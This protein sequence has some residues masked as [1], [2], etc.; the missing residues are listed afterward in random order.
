MLEL[1]GYD[2]SRRTFNQSP[3]ELSD[4]NSA[5]PEDGIPWRRVLHC[6]SQLA[7]DSAP[8]CWCYGEAYTSNFSYEGFASVD[9]DIQPEDMKAKIMM[10]NCL[11]FP[12]FTPKQQAHRITVS[13]AQ[14]LVLHPCTSVAVAHG[15]SCHSFH[16]IHVRTECSC[17]MSQT[18]YAHY[19][20]YCIFRWSFKTFYRRHISVTSLVM[21]ALK[22]KPDNLR[23]NTELD[24]C[25]R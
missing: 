10:V 9:R 13:W 24:K 17:A 5:V 23:P 22:L 14:S 8:G 1:P 25:C 2:G 3:P 18:L 15:P 21:L 11:P 4:S 16:F 19:I 7:D 12:K 6:Y 20:F